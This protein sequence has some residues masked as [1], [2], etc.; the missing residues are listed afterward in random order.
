MEAS[1]KLPIFK[2]DTHNVKEHLFILEN[3]WIR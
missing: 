2:K 3:D 1:T